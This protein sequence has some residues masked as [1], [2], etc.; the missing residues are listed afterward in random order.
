[1][2]PRKLVEAL[3]PYFPIMDGEYSCCLHCGGPEYQHDG[4]SLDQH[5]TGCPWVKA[6]RLLGDKLPATRPASKPYP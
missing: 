1:M 4:R 6:R 2:I 5:A 3:A